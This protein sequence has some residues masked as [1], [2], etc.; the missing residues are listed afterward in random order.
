MSR[1]S[2]RSGLDISLAL[3]RL[4]GKN[5]TAGSY[6]T[7]R[8]SGSSPKCTG[9]VCAENRFAPSPR[10][11][12]QRAQKPKRRKAGTLNP[13]NARSPTIQ[14]IT[15]NQ[16]TRRKTHVRSTQRT[17]AL[18][19]NHRG[20][21]PCNGTTRMALATDRNGST[22]RPRRIEEGLGLPKHFQ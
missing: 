5:K 6:P 12:T 8:S 4:G 11:S 18:S 14:K 7:F 21:C 15:N 20:R 10:S 2:N 9:S 19:R 22:Y 13:S 3:C 17:H 16:I 1:N